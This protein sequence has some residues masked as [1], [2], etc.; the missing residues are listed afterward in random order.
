ML[1][2]NLL[3]DDLA[4]LRFG[5]SPLIEISNSYRYLRYHPEALTFY[6]GWREEAEAALHGLS[7]P[8]LDAVILEKHYIADFMTPTPLDTVRTFDDA[9][10][11]LRR[12]PEPTLRANLETILQL[13]EPLTPPR[14]HFLDDPCGALERLA[15]EVAIYWQRALAPYWGHMLSVLEND[16]LYRA[17]QLA[18]F[19]A[20]SVFA[21]LSHSLT[22]APGFISIDKRYVCRASRKQHYDLGGVGLQLVPAIFGKSSSVSTQ[23][24]PEFRPM[25]IYS[26]RGAGLWHHEPSPANVQLET[27]IGA[28]KSRVLLALEAPQNT[29]ELARILNLTPGAVSQHLGHLS[30]AGL[31]EAHRAG[32]RVFYRL[33]LRGERLLGLF[34]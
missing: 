33:S 32:S 7:F 2:V 34:D 22:Y 21:E 25:I 19:G 4:N 23:F 1:T 18:L 3:P 6:R 14:Q 30:S 11:T 26:A 8:Y 24:E 17:R 31:V 27:L 29:T 20:R 15:D 9:L 16:V 5:Y 28:G 10:D 13:D 12:T